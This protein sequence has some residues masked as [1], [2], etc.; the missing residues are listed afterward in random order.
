MR[1]YWSLCFILIVASA[2]LANETSTSL[3]NVDTVPPSNKLLSQFEM[4]SPTQIEHG[5]RLSAVL[6]CIGCHTPEL[7]GE[8]WSDPEL[9]V[10]W[11]ANLTRSAADYSK[12]ELAAMITDGARP[13]RALMDMPSFLFSELH[14]D[15]MSAL[16]HYLKSLPAKGEKHPEPTIGPALAKQIESGEFKDSVQAVAEMKDQAPPDLGPNHAFARYILRATCAEC[17]GM[18]LEGN[19]EPMSD[20]PPRPS[21]RIIAA[22]SEEDFTKLMKT[23]KPVGDRELKMMGGVARWRYSRFTDNEIKA[24]YEYLV[25]LT[26]QPLEN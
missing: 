18:N 13:D 6:G 26:K 23:G 19:I 2:A 4:A 15:D 24:I 20:A 14:P 12:E 17:H 5:E 25:A 22:Y 3:S 8:D 10:L 11:T 1:N 9:G 7:T 21:L 16:L